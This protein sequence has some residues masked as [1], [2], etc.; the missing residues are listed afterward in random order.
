M[1]RGHWQLYQALDPQL[2]AGR[3]R[4]LL[5]AP[6]EVTLQF[7]DGVLTA[8]GSLPRHGWSTASAWHRSYPASPVTMPGR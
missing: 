7:A 1:S 5:R 6:D 2:V 3:A 8:G 4:L